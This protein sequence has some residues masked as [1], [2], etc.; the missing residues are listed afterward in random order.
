MDSGSEFLKWH[1]SSLKGEQL[2]KIAMIFQL[3]LQKSLKNYYFTK[4]EMKFGKVSEIWDDYIFLHYIKPA[5][6]LIIV[7]KLKKQLIYFLI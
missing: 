6:D 5:L 3:R 4:R 2:Y 7:N 1:P